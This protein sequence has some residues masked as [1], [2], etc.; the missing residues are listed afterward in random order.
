[1]DKFFFKKKGRSR[2]RIKA[3]SKQQAQGKAEVRTPSETHLDCGILYFSFFY[4]F[5]YLEVHNK[6]ETGIDFVSVCASFLSTRDNTV[7]NSVS[8][9]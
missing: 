9:L 4:L 8:F 5:F 7:L 3:S 6:N 2:T 1:M